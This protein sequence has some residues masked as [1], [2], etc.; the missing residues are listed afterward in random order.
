MAVKRTVSAPNPRKRS[1]HELL[2]LSSLALAVA[3]AFPGHACAA[4]Y[5]VSNQ[6]ELFAAINAA[7]AGSDPSSTIVLSGDLALATSAMLPTPNKPLTIDTR[8]FTLSGMGAASGVNFSSGGGTLTIRGTLYG[9]DGTEVAGSASNGGAG[10]GV[11]RGS[12]NLVNNGTITGGN[13][14]HASSG[15][16]GGLGVA[17]GAGTFINNGT[18]TGGVGDGGLASGI[19]ATLTSGGTLTNH[20]TIQGGASRTGTGGIGLE[21]NIGGGTLNNDGTVK[22]GESLGGTATGG[23]G[24][25]ASA[26]GASVINNTGMIE[27]GSGA[28]AIHGVSSLNIVNSGTISAGAGQAN[29]IQL[30]STTRTIT[31]QLQAGWAINGNVVGGTTANDTLIL[32]GSANA[33]FDISAVGA[34]AQYQNFDIFQKTG[35]STWSLVGT[36]TASTPWTIQQGTLQLGNGGTSG[37]FVGD[38]TNNGAL[39]FNRSNLLTFANVISG[40]GSVS[41]VGTG[42]TVLTGANTYTG[43]T[44]I[45]AGSLR[46]TS[47]GNLG[48]VAGGLTFTGGTLATGADIASARTVAL[49][50]TGTLATDAGTTF[51]LSGVVSGNGGLTKMGGGTLVLTGTNTYAG[52][53]SIDGGEVRIASDANLGASA[54]ALSFAGG[55]LHTTADIAMNRAVALGGTGTFLT[56]AGTTLAEGGAITGSGALV[57][58]GNGSLVLA[59]NDTYGGGTTIAAGTLQVGNGGTSGSI[60]GNVRDNGAIAFDRSD[61][62]TFAG[63]VS[64]AGMLAQNGN[65]TTVLTGAN[66][67]AGGTTISGGTLQLGDGGTGGSIVGNVAN[68]GKLVFD[69]SDVVDFSGTISGGGSVVQAGTGNTVFNG[70]QTYTGATSVEAGRLSVNGSITSAVT[71]H[72]AGTLGGAGT[73]FGD[74]TNIG[75]VA[76]GNSIGKLTVAG[77][78]A[79]QG[80]TLA[81][82]AALGDDSSATDRLVV[83]GD[84]SGITNVKVTNV[85]GSGALTVQGIQIVDVQGASNGSFNLVGDYLYQGQPAVV[86]GAYAYR[87]YKN[88]LSTP[89][90]GDWYL[91]SQVIA[92]ATGTPPATPVTSPLYAPNV[93]LYEVYAGVLQRLNQLGT[94]QQRVG[95]PDF[96]A[97]DSSA[98]NH[99]R[100]AA[101]WVRVHT[102]HADFSPETSIVGADYAVTTQKL[103]V[104][105][106]G[107]LHEGDSGVL[108]A[109]VTAQSGKATSNVRSAFGEGRIKATGY[110][111]GGTLTWYGAGGFYI[112]AQAQW[113]RYRSDIDSY[114]LARQLA[115]G[116][117]GSGYDLGVEA[118]QKFAL[119]DEWSLIPQGQLTYSSV[120]FDG[121]VDPYGADVSRRDG[122][123]LEARAGLAVDHLSAWRSESGM[124][125]AHVYGIGN[126]YYDFM[127]GT[128]ADVSGLTL[129]SKNAPL[130]GGLGIGGSLA[131]KD[132]RYRLFGETL[133]QTSLQH[134]GDSTSYSLRVGFNMRW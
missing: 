33:T 11:N 46:I 83:T 67:Y 76:P 44:T 22:G 94:L 59:G 28:A 75:T 34:A 65:G 31:L 42:E 39:A 53:T 18:V 58:A 6:T 74:V 32:G 90:D 80:G 100:P 104:G 47:D 8:G 17:Q 115:N 121:F 20:G 89:N 73:I 93:P 84:T 52:G 81:I 116:N 125:R 131:W 66:T 5:T 87:L 86:S 38:V 45:S 106:D 41:Q 19:G 27:G 118:G 64:G 108:V 56:D 119:N 82:E 63:V 99:A 3:C 13:G 14:G 124:N 95:S 78:Y 71:V 2:A 4:N 37:I 29:A 70:A 15:N 69:R 79:G 128:K 109:G 49:N 16:Y 61:T 134:F 25:Y 10:L 114:T 36:G 50:G 9:G 105:V 43:G 97:D 103:Q 132:G 7:N 26:T 123:S 72:V 122:D 1:R 12:S 30:G 24:V 129:N 21:F 85:G 55:T 54:G 107:L 113:N 40:S 133:A 48:D 120:R 117:H 111:I 23:Y 98:S 130:W 102:D 92:S 101:A 35:T 127:G 77:D 91:R 57:K 62:V 51:T 88:G 126:L 96:N 112:D 68:G 60:V 110:G